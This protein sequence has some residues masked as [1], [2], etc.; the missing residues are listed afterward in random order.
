MLLT[1]LA[2]TTDSLPSVNDAT[3]S[4]AA[5]GILAGV[6]IFI[7]VLLIIG[8]I[9]LAFN[10]WMIIDCAARKDSDFPSNNKSTWL[11]LLIVGLLF[12]FGWIVG[13]VYFFTV[14]K[15]AGKGGGTSAPAQSSGTDTP[16]Q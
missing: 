9:L 8:I 2:Q 15:K 1:L 3:N 12:S 14:R 5:T 4:A 13:L 7:L 16:A 11:I 6:G 10:I